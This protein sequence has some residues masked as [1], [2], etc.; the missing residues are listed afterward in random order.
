[1]GRALRLGQDRG[2]AAANEHDRKY[3]KLTKIV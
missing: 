1:M 3:V 2:S